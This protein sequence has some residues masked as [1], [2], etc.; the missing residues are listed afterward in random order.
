MGAFGAGK[1]SGFS[2]RAITSECRWRGL[3]RKLLVGFTLSAGLLGAP[4]VGY[5]SQYDWVLDV[6]DAGGDPSASGDYVSYAVTITNS[7][8]ELNPLASPATSLII[9]VPDNT[10]LSEVTTLTCDQALPVDGP[11][12]VTCT[13][14]ALDIDGTVSFAVILRT[15]AEG[16]IELKARIPDTNDTNP[17]NNSVAETTTI[18]P[19]PGIPDVPP[20]PGDTDVALS[21]TGPATAASGSVVSYS[22]TVTNNGPDTL[23]GA[24]IDIPAIT[25]FRVTS[26]GSNGSGGYRCPVSGSV[27][28][29]ANT[30]VNVTGKVTLPSGPSADFTVA[31]TVGVT[32]TV[33]SVASNNT[34]SQLT[35][36]TAGSDVYVSM[37]NSAGNLALVGDTENVTINAGFT[38]DVPQGLSFSTTIAP[39]YTITNT[40]SISGDWTCNVAGQVISCSRPSNALT[41][42]EAVSLGSVVVDVSVNAAGTD[43]QN[44]VAITSTSP[45][46][47][48]LSNNTDT[49]ALRTTEVPIVTLGLSKSGPNPALMVVGND[50]NFSLDF[51]NN[52][53]TRL[54]GEVTLTD[55]LPDGLT[56]TGYSGAGWTCPAAPIVGPAPVVCTRNYDEGANEFLAPGDTT[57]ALVLETRAVSPGVRVN[58]G[59]V[60]ATRWPDGGGTASYGFEIFDVPAS[61]DVTI[62]KTA[63][64]NPVIIGDSQ[65]FNIEV[66]NAGPDTSSD[67][68][69][70]DNLTDLLNGLT[71]PT[72]AGFIGYSVS[73]NAA[74]T[75]TFTCTV[76]PNGRSQGLVC[77]IDSLPVCTAGTDCPIITVN[78]RPG[79]G[80]SDGVA[81]SNTANI[82]SLGVG[83][84]DLNNGSSTANYNVVK[85]TDVT[86]SLSASR[87]P[88]IAGQNLA[89]TVTAQNPSNAR[90]LSYA[91]NTIVTT[92][93]PSDVVFVS[94]SPSSG[95]CT[96]VP[97]AGAVISAANN[98]IVCDLGEVAT[99]GSKRVNILVK[100]LESL[101]GGVMAASAS[102][103][104]TT[105]ELDA[106]NNS[107]ALN[108][109]VASPAFDI[110][111][112]NIDDVDPIDIGSDM[113]YT[114][115][116]RNLG[117]SFAENVTVNYAMPT[118]LLTYQSHVAA[119]GTC[120]TVP[121]IGSV[122]GTLSCTFPRIDA[123]QE[124]VIIITA[125]AIEKGSAQTNA[126]LSSVAIG[127]GADSQPLNNTE[128]E[129]TTVRTRA[130]VELVSKV[131][132][133]SEVEL[134]EAFNYTITVRNNTGADLREADDVEVTDSLPTGM[135]L[136]GTPTVAVVT[137]TISQSTCTN[138]A[139]NRSFSCTLGTLSS[140]GQA[141]I[142]VPV[143]VT[144]AASY[145]VT[146][147]NTAQII[148][149]SRDMNEGNNN[150]SGPVDVVDSS[151][152]GQVYY[153]FNNNGLQEAVDTGVEGLE[154]TLTGT[155]YDGVVV[156]MTTT[157]AADGTY[158]FDGLQSGTYAI[159]R[160]STTEGYLLDGSSFVGTSGGTQVSPTEVN[161]IGLAKKIDATAYDFSVIPQARVG[162]AQRVSAAPTI[163][164]DGSFTATFSY[165]VENFSPDPLMNVEVTETLSGAAPSLGSF[166]SL[167]ASVTEGTYS[168]VSAPSGTCN[169]LNA[170]FNGDTVSS[171]ISSGTLA[172]NSSCTISVQVKVMP[173]KPSAPV[174]LPHNFTFQT[175]SR[176]TAQGNYT[177]QIDANYSLL[178]DLS[179]DGSN[180]D[181]NGNG[182]A[183]DAGE[184]DP[185]VFSPTYDPQVRLVKT[186]D[187]SALSNPVQPG[188][189]ITYNYAIT[190]TGNLNLSAVELVDLMDGLNLGGLPIPLLAPGQTDRV[191]YSGTYAVTQ[192]DIDTGYV[193][194]TATVSG[195]DP[196]AAVVSDVSGTATDNDTITSAALAQDRSIALI[197]TA[198]AS[199]VN[200]PA[201]VGDQISYS[202]TVTNTGNINLSNVFITDAL[203][204]IAL[205]GGPLAALAPGETD[206][207]TF[208]ATYILKQ[209]DLDNA[210]VENTAT[211]TGT[212]R[213]GG[214]VTDTSGTTV[215][216][217][218]PTVVPLA[219]AP[220]IDLVKTADTSALSKDIGKVGEM[221]SYS[222]AV[223]NTGTVTLT[224][225]TLTDALAG[226]NLSGGPIA[227]LAPGATD[228]STYTATYNL[229]AAD[230]VREDV[231]NNASVSGQYGVDGG[232]SPLL[233][234]DSDRVVTTIVFIEAVAEVF[235]PFTTD[236]GTTTS[237]LA[238]DRFGTLPAT[239]A[240][241]ILTVEASDPELTLDTNTALITLAPGN[242]SGEYQ[243]TYKICRR[244]NPTACDT[245]TETVV[246]GAIDGI[247]AT[248]T[249]MFSD[250]G[251]GLDGVGDTITYTIAVQNTGNTTLS[252]VSLA[253]TFLT[254]DTATP[255]TLDSGPTFV[256]ADTGSLEGDLLPGEIAN[257]EARFVLTVEAVDGGGLSNQV[258]ASGLPVYPA[259]VPG[260]PE[261]ISDL[262]DDG[263]DTDGNVV[264]DPTV[265]PLEPLMI[266]QALRLTKTTSRQV[267]ERGTVVP[268]TITITNDYARTMGPMN[269]LD[270]LPADFVYVVDTASVDGAPTSVE[271]IGNT[272][273]LPDLYI[274]PFA[275]I[276]AKLSARILVSADVG[277]HVNRAR[278]RDSVTGQLLAPE[279]SATVTII[280]EPVFDCGDVYGK[281]FNDL[282]RDGYQNKP[283]NGVVENGI[284]SARVTGV[285]G[286]IITTDEYGRFHVPCA[287]LP[288]DRGS[289]FI[290][291]LDHR[292]L[293]AGYRLTTENPRVV[294][295][296]PGKMTELNFGA[297]L[298]RVVR[299]DL[300]ESGFNDGFLKPEFEEALDNLVLQINSEPVHLNLV[301]HLPEKA[302]R[303]T[304]QAAFKKMKQVELRIRDQWSERPQDELTFDKNIIHF[305]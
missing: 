262:S 283:E 234:N 264:D 81:L 45:T 183:E 162:L 180:P 200:N 105:P 139:N 299:I 137:G 112:N 63:V 191:A 9:D 136:T 201:Q 115:T 108:V 224:N 148:T 131:V 34:A 107:A 171:L 61:A 276:T 88:A 152:S 275:T 230:I 287:M 292:S 74:A 53:N 151:I 134:R 273:K 29:G 38:G 66:I 167:P 160:G 8:D 86:V 138:A 181:P 26:C 84:P 119:G 269:L 182:F 47:P 233:V 52:G 278:L 190:N 78:T 165:V 118:A 159:T 192:D 213:V 6:S 72:D 109:N 177:G 293:P 58:Q 175:Q 1:S 252:G 7:A 196:F 95:T 2:S 113:N 68:R 223:T 174:S 235:P 189:I 203:P 305:N 101:R 28:S 231:E 48:D 80:V 30:Q 18:T 211:V 205:S 225:V 222:F 282:N 89:Y 243:V 37:S 185:T 286:T 237:M 114:V 288:K 93:L 290:L 110:L 300:S 129:H 186:A 176:V 228:T 294:R 142:T 238:S 227:S 46:D 117:P 291:K 27:V 96:T 267:V 70:T 210:K 285:D 199:L 42:G 83:D 14:P 298:P 265:Y 85:R 39:E 36:V 35:S 158:T 21:V 57:P 104:T 92:T 155:A 254:L 55:S 195:T 239:L 43:V 122:G 126:S 244:D 221:I 289:N 147:T 116:A 156:N 121:A 17:V 132:D 94:A 125:R 209:S 100:P 261:P 257:Y 128:D 188:E 75:S 187:T 98:Q 163:N 87:D 226:V 259:G 102:V 91:Q 241:V 240:D 274:S 3:A 184:N 161:T 76:T 62:S 217:D 111:I 56:Y 146:L 123:G 249:Q 5:A 268:Y 242:P 215:T 12:T 258:E 204:D 170:S 194:N 33:D 169:G 19:G 251:D 106:T 124:Q 69:V 135:V 144:S 301:F 304:R 303:P 23:S 250:E 13:V 73:K 218:D 97:V 256:S 120:G 157:T 51:T 272:V 295:L 246:Q 31:G 82:I 248:K 44:S 99:G 245:A 172:A 280:P 25:G 219:I 207:S 24:Y 208:T 168:I 40:R 232:G 153:D 247:E 60:V 253:D 302:S 59:D 212:A 54:F 164:A 255:I 279:A 10:L 141:T 41:A 127:E 193:E 197:K 236:G 77:N 297:T 266:Q 271:V 15:K 65:T 143:N 270:I 220:S 198:D 179:D 130:D 4:V 150:G 79:A 133:K 64:S 263:D 50:Y 281:V 260:T 149:S 284:P 296:T 277:D 214:T 173:V 71:G 154:L 202:F 20:P 67:V 178:E 206:T 16:V 166:V 32:S 90:Y 140:G 49:D 11:S 216:N 229:V 22:F 145:P 103:T